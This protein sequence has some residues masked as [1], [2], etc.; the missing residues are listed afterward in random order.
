[1]TDAIRPWCAKARFPG[2][3]VFLGGTVTLPFKARHDEIVA[4]LEAH[5]LEFLPP[6]FEIIEPVCGALFFQ[7]E[8]P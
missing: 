8:Q 1:M 6:G 3:A 7:E 5:F 4:A 2:L